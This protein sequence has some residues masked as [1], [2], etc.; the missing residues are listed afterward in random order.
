MAA[1]KKQL[2]G[3]NSFGGSNFSIFRNS[4]G[5]PGAAFHSPFLG[6]VHK[7]VC[8]PPVKNNGMYNIEVI[9]TD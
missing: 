4:F 5:I 2:S 3:M 1:T 7:N 6:I 8:S 9:F